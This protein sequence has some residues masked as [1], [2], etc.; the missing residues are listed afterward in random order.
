MRQY[1]GI[2]FHAHC[3]TTLPKVLPQL[4][5]PPPLLL[6][7]LHMQPRCHHTALCHIAGAAEVHLI[8]L[9]APHSMA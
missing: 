1:S 9:R 3:F 4:L 8:P 6:Q 5:L 2:W 7:L